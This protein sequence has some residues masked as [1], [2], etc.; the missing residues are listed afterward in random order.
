MG[1]SAAIPTEQMK[2]SLG[3][4]IE[5]SEKE[6][7]SKMCVTLP[8]LLS[9]PPEGKGAAFLGYSGSSVSQNWGTGE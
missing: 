9:S 7:K 6:R 2:L 1:P 4:I 8:F 3:G 5:I